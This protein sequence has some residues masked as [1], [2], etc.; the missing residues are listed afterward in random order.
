MSLL[1]GKRALIVE[2]E[3]A[4][5]LMLEGMLLDLG[6]TSVEI[7][8][9]LDEG[10]AAADADTVDFALLDVNL[11]GRESYPI[12]DRLTERGV[13]F[14]FAT[15]Y[16]RRG[17]ATAYQNRGVLGKPILERDLEAALRSALD[18]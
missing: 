13:P 7:A 10:L 5:A 8:G 15:G 9:S 14:V 12:A 3:G 16:G 17:V 11:A 6:C 1:A 4:I 18:R 2:D